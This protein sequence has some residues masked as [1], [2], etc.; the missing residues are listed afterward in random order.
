VM[1]LHRRWSEA[2]H[3]TYPILEVPLAL[4]SVDKPLWASSI[5]TVGFGLA[6]AV[7]TLNSLHAIAPQWPAIPV[8]AWHDPYNLVG[9][10]TDHPWNAIGYMPL[11]FYPFA[12]GQGLLLPTNLSFSCWFFYLQWQ[13]QKVLTAWLGWSG[14]PGAPFIREQSFGGFIG[15]ALFAL[16]VS[17]RGWLRE[18]SRAF[19]RKP[20]VGSWD[21]RVALLAT[22]TGFGGLVWFSCRAGMTT[23]YAIAFFA[24][25]FLIGIAITRIRAEMGLPVHDL[26][27]S[28]P[29]QMLPTILGVRGVGQRNLLVGE[30]YYWFNRAYRSH[31]MPHQA[32][33]FK[34]LS[35]EVGLGPGLLLLV[36]AGGLGV[37]LSFYL[38]LKMVFAAGGAAGCV[39]N[40]PMYI[41]REPW[42]EFLSWTDQARGPNARATIAIVAGALVTFLGMLG[43]V[44]TGW[45]PV[46]PVGYAVSS[47][48]AMERLWCPLLVAWT[49][50]SLVTRYGGGAQYKKLVQF[51][52]GLVIGDFVA[53]SFWNIHGMLRHLPIYRFWD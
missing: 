6:A 17:R 43:H 53:G 24:V 22:V 41:G 18:L 12:I 25:F 30:V 29:T 15:L 23:P 45:W 11:S 47:S 20:C 46:H 50:K 8:R 5:F 27:Y 21:A 44:R 13:A 51:A 37:A 32:E 34:F 36:L 33:G 31:F 10:V 7:E 28:G 38:Q 35:S 26:H 3:L 16:W 9:Q 4:S 49:V 48:W 42:F 2:E 1:L 14:T 52:V 39:A 40:V 19:D